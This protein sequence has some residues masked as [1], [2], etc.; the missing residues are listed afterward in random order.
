MTQPS[1]TE[2]TPSRRERFVARSVQRSTALAILSPLAA[3]AWVLL[4]PTGFVSVMP[5]WFWDIDPGWT[6]LAWLVGLVLISAG[7]P[8]AVVLAHVSV[9]AGAGWRRSAAALVVSYVSTCFML[10]CWIVLIGLAT[11]GFD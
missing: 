9:P 10:W 4:V 7:P 3:L 11:A 2:T 1:S 5:D 8:V 6:A